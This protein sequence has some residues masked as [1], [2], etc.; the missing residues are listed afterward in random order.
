[1]VIKGNVDRLDVAKE[2]RITHSW[3]WGREAQ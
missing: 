3:G 1:M 2:S